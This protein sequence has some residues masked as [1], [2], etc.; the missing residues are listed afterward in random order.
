MMKR[1]WLKRG[2][3][4]ER[5]VKPS[6]AALALLVKVRDQIAG[7]PGSWGAGMGNR[8]FSKGFDERHCV[9]GWMAVLSGHSAHT[10]PNEIIKSGGTLRN[11]Y[12]LAA[13]LLAE[14]LNGNGINVVQGM[15]RD[16]VVWEHNDA[17]GMSVATIVGD[18]NR[19]I[20]Y[21]E[22]ALA[23]GTA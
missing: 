1:N 23:E 4:K 10:Y 15:V 6:K 14:T 13:A 9:L 8:S 2:D 20:R 7:K 21:A 3:G 18:L 22:Y 5:K 12:P 16:M 11:Q 19:T 17:D